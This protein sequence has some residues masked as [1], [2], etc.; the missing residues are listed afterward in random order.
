MRFSSVTHLKV[1]CFRRQSQM[2]LAGCFTL[3]CHNASNQIFQGQK[4]CLK[5][6]SLKVLTTIISASHIL[7]PH[8]RFRSCHMSNFHQQLSSTVNR[9]STV[10]FNRYSTQYHSWNTLNYYSIQQSEKNQL[11]TG[12]WYSYPE[13]SRSMT[14]SSWDDDIPFIIPFIIPF[15]GKNHQIHV[16]QIPRKLALLLDLEKSAS[17]DAPKK[18][19][20]TRDA[21]PRPGSGSSA[22]VDFCWF[23][24]APTSSSHPWFPVKNHVKP[25]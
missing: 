16:P 10:Q 7:N 4:V 21:L 13:K 8:Y 5:S 23:Q 1:A 9:S 2:K 19:Q 14:S 17:T 6:Y 12:C 11:F 20:G 22:S 3:W 15:P 24:P 18:G 25:P